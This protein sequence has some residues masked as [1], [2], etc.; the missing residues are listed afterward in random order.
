MDI[1]T[2]SI[3]S[4]YDLASS[5]ASTSAIT[6]SLDK[7]YSN[8]SDEE[9]LDACKEFESYFI[10]QVLKQAEESLLMNEDEDSG[11]ISQVKTYAKEG[12]IT[13]YAKMISDSGSIG[14]ANKLYEQMKR[15]YNIRSQYSCF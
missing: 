9:L 3:Q 13:Q 11:S 15:N 4:N 5:N 12:L 1:L 6:N 2:S 8:S 10:E 14:L 7:D